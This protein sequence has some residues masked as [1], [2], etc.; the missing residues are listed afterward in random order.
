MEPNIQSQEQDHTLSPIVAIIPPRPQDDLGSKDR[1][2]KKAQQRLPTPK[3][4][5]EHM[6]W[7]MRWYLVIAITTA[8]TLS[9][10]SGLL[11]YWITRD[12]HYLLFIAPTTLIPFVRYI[13][14]MDKK[15]FDLKLATINNKKELV[16]AKLRVQ[17]LEAELGKQQSNKSKTPARK[18]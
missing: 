13:V 3:D 11:G 8:Y 14:P 2:Q 6:T 9:V 16:E 17:M 5:D 15:R 18:T 1:Q 12:L 7:R 4:F 10:I